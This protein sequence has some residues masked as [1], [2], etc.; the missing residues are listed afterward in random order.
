MLIIF[1]RAAGLSLRGLFASQSV[2]RFGDL[3]ALPRAINCS[4]RLVNFDPKTP[5][6][7]GYAFEPAMRNHNASPAGRATSWNIGDHG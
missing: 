7:V 3:D 4:P 2:C 6:K 1:D 5:L